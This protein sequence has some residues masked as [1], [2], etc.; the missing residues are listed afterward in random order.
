MVIAEGLV[1]VRCV[2]VCVCVCVR[3]CV[4]ERRKGLRFQEEMNRWE[5]QTDKGC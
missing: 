1:Q 2:C 5:G 4:R 3:A